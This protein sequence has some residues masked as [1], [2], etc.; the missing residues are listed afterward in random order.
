MK[1]HFG[2][3]LKE[4]RGRRRMKSGQAIHGENCKPRVCLLVLNYVEQGK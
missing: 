1:Y 2:H 4:K 3:Q